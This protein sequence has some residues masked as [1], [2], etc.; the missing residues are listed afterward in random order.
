[1]LIT[2]GIK[3]ERDFAIISNALL[4]DVALSFRARGILSCLLSHAEGYRVSSDRLADMGTEGRDAIRSA[5][6]ELEAAGYLKRIKTQDDRGQWATSAVISDTPD[7]REQ[8]HPAPEKPTPGNPASVSQSSVFQALKEDQEENYKKKEKKEAAPKISF[9]GLKFE[10]LPNEQV[11]AWKQAYP[12]V[13]VPGEILKAASW[14]D[15]NPANRKS[16]YKRFLNGWLSRA[17]DKAPAQG[18]AQGY[19]AAPAYKTTPAQRPQAETF[20]ERDARLKREEWERSNGRPW[21]EQDLPSSARQ[22]TPYTLDAETR[23]LA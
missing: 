13:N 3:P 15:A 23:R 4:R 18:Y 14:L 2:R 12:A 11:E 8:N 22:P 20:A 17:Q 19:G 9:D 1:M 10:S 7:F 16:D 21:P 5:L 6:V